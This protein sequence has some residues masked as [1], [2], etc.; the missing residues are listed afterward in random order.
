[1]I[2]FN[3]YTTTTLSEMLD[4]I[5]S[6]F[7]AAGLV[8]HDRQSATLTMKDGTYYI[9]FKNNGNYL[10]MSVSLS[11]TWNGNYLDSYI[12]K[13]DS[14]SSF[15]S[16]GVYNCYIGVAKKDNDYCV[17]MYKTNSVL[18]YF[19]VCF[20]RLKTSL[21]RYVWLD[22]YTQKYYDTTGT[23]IGTMA[24]QIASLNITD[25]T[26]LYKKNLN[27]TLTG[28]SITDDEFLLNVYDICFP[29]TE[30]SRVFNYVMND[31]IYVTCTNQGTALNYLFKHEEV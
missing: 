1:M 7:A 17:G 4:H 19:P 9:G 25:A 24:H 26:V 21:D 30:S 15:Y 20:C 31:G 14:S 2:R 3:N 18:Q 22:S 10:Y 8:L 11:D 29:L 5:Q 27:V 6:D 12:Y 28:G 16:G 23:N 13:Y